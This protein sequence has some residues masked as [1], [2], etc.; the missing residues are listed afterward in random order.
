MPIDPS[1]FSADPDLIRALDRRATPV[2]CRAERI[3]FNQGD[4]P[5]GLY[6][7]KSGEATLV[8][9][10]PSGE[11]ITSILATTGSLLGLPAVVSDKPYSLTAVAHTSAH[12]TFLPR[13]DFLAIMKSNPAIALKIL[14]VLAAEVRSARQSII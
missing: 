7:L 9:H 8:L 4:N 5:V 11:P 2:D 10:S 14:A 3:L 12:V 1:S 13:G 6:I